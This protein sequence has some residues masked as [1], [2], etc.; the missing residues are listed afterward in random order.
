MTGAQVPRVPRVT[1]AIQGEPVP[2]VPR[3][4]KVTRRTEYRC[5]GPGPQVTRVDKEIPV[6]RVPGPGSRDKGDRVIRCHGSSQGDKGP[7]VPQAKGDKG[8]TGDSGTRSRTS[9]DPADSGFSRSQ[10]VDH[11]RSPIRSACPRGETV[12][13]GGVV[14]SGLSDVWAS[15]PTASG[16]TASVTRSL[17]SPEV[18]TGTVY[19]I[20]ADSTP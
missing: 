6:P 17:F 18:V 11:S 5:P 2:Q 14:M 1:R 12:L 16:W 8:D 3:V 19:A 9:G 13:G 4:P 7:A 15:G 10:R 20:C